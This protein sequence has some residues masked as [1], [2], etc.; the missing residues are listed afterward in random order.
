MIIVS[1][2]FLLKTDYK[3]VKLFSNVHKNGKIVIIRDDYHDIGRL[4][5]ITIIDKSKNW[6]TSII[7]KENIT[8]NRQ[9]R[10]IAH[11]YCTRMHFNK[12]TNE[13]LNFYYNITFE[14]QS[15]HILSTHTALHACDIS[16]MCDNNMAIHVVLG[17]A[18]KLML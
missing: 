3:H 12:N 16:N 8:V 6:T 5:L 9:N 2:S 18:N 7:V 13:I 1:T 15:F 14:G 11:P 4:L 17:Y 10:S